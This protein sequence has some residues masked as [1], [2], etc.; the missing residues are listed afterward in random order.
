MPHPRAPSLIPSASATAATGSDSMSRRT[1]IRRSSSGNRRI[2]SR[3]RC[4]V[5]SGSAARWD[6]TR[7][8][9]ADESATRPP[10]T[11]PGRRSAGPRGCVGDEAWP[12]GPER[13]DRARG[14]GAAAGSADSRAGSGRP[15]PAPPGPRRKGRSVRR[16]AGRAGPRSSAAAGRAGPRGWPPPPPGRP[17]GLAR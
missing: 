8:R 4:L 3:T 5:S 2:A 1:R 17:H 6:S 9:P 14:T 11:P 13:I 12:G 10:G 7:R 16:A 15:P